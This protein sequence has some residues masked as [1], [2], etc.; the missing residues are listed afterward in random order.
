M[1]HL[2]FVYKATVIL[3]NDAFHEV[4][5]NF[6]SGCA[7]EFDCAHSRDAAFS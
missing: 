1:T 6:P 4:I 3:K 2:L 7:G 5:I